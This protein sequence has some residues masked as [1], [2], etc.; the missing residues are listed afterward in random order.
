V[1]EEGVFEWR[2]ALAGVVRAV[3]VC[4]LVCRGVRGWVW[5]SRSTA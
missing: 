5:R 2:Q 3:L 4:R 1:G